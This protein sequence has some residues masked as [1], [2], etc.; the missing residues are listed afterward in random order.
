LE[1]EQ[2]AA[3]KQEAIKNSNVI[4][5]IFCID[6]DYQIKLFSQINIVLVK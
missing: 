2:P 6:S 4:F 3:S 1:E 5:F